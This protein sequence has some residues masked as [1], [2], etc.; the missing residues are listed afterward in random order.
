[1]SEEFCTTPITSNNI[2]NNSDKLLYFSFTDFC[3]NGCFYRNNNVAFDIKICCKYSAVTLK[4]KKVFLIQLRPNNRN[5][6]SSFPPIKVK[7]N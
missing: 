1:M 2:V 7:E 6:T 5:F 3:N 4:W